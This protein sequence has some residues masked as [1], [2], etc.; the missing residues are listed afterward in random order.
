[1]AGCLAATAP[2]A[3]ELLAAYLLI[4]AAAGV[5]AQA[6]NIAGRHA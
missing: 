3:A 6:G 2:G 5:S 4:G 1:M